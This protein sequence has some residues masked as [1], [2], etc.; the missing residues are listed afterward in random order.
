[1]QTPL[2]TLALL[3]LAAFALS[4]D[5][6]VAEVQDRPQHAQA[7]G[8]PVE[9]GQPERLLRVS[10]RILITRA[11][12]IDPDPEVALEALTELGNITTDAAT[13]EL[14]TAVYRGRDE[15]RRRASAGALLTLGE[16]MVAEGAL[17]RGRRIGHALWHSSL[18]WGMR[19][20]AMAL[21][22]TPEPPQEDGD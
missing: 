14:L 18:Q 4:D 3:A 20:R 2:L 8:P 7:G 1:M 11:K 17:E 19:D 12:A 15:A 13:E 21:W 6:P 10:T 5:D 16:R 22:K 9:A